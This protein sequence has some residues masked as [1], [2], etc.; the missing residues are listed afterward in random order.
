MTTPRMTG[1]PT[2]GHAPR[3]ADTVAEPWPGRCLVPAP[4]RR[5]TACRVVLAEEPP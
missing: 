2:I 5:S 1:V 4:I 3:A